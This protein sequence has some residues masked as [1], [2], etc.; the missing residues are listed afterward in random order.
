M[1]RFQ[2]GTAVI[3]RGPHGQRLAAIV[4]GPWED[5]SFDLDCQ[6]RVRR[7]QMIEFPDGEMVE[8]HSASMNSWIPARLLH[9]GRAVGT[10]DL[11]C[12]EGVEIKRIRLPHG[13]GAPSTPGPPQ[14]LLPSASSGG[15]PLKAGEFVFYKSGTHGWIPAKVISARPGDETC[16]LDVKPNASVQQ[17]FRL[18]D[19]AMVEYFSQSSN[20][21]IPARLLRPSGPG[22]DPGSFD[23]DCKQ[24]VPITKIRPPPDAAGGAPSP[25]PKMKSRGG[26]AAAT[27]GG[28]WGLFGGEDV[29]EDG[30]GGVDKGG[31]KGGGKGGGKDGKPGGYD[32][33]ASFG[34]QM[35]PQVPGTMLPGKSFKMPLW[36]YNPP[37]GRHM[38]IRAEPNIEGR[39]SDKCLAAGEIFCVS[40]EMQGP[41]GVLY[42]E[43]ADG[44]GW[45]FDHKPGFGPM[46][47][48]YLIDEEDSSAHYVV[49]NDKL[50]V[51]GAR[52]RGGD[53]DVVGKLGAGACVKVKEVVTLADQHRVRGRIE[54]PAGWITLLDL[55][56]GRRCA[57]K[58]QQ[59]IAAL[60]TG[61]LQQR[62]SC[63]GFGGSR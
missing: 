30:Y 62:Q 58:S 45:V 61:A 54:Q 38:D 52:A 53:G 41:Q 25:A 20:S 17:I 4:G 1:P 29:A 15:G 19:G 51:T 12:K 60:A 7:E 63:F 8:Y 36:S 28:F 42:L 35:P 24:C 9:E 10:F 39:R 40:Q 57:V 34:R 23:L 59:K 5:G 2:P 50:A 22:A 55:Q 13:Q 18:P 14:T 33:G 49:I 3:F 31:S 44:R 26:A 46:C 48:R 32:G 6:Q 43:I 21:W 11:D 27:G 47:E 56:S 37:D 16:D